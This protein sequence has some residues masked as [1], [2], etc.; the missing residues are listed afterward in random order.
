MYRKEGDKKMNTNYNSQVSFNGQLKINSL[1]F[2]EVK[3][4]GG[5]ERWQE[6]AK[7]F[8]KLTKNNKDVFELMS[9]ENHQGLPVIQV[10]KNYKNNKIDLGGFGGANYYELVQSNITDIANKLANFVQNG[11]VI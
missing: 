5:K 6:I 8:E 7:T 10:Y 11:K 9:A 3:S 1:K 4:L 2:K